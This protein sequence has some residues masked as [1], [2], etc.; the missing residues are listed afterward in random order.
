MR[1]DLL[2][3]QELDLLNRQLKARGFTTIPTEEEVARG[4]RDYLHRL[5]G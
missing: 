5:R 4:I 1:D 3:A 2:S